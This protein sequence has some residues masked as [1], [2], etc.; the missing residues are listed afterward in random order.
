MPLAR[1]TRRHTVQKAYDAL[2]SP[3][4][5]SGSCA[6]RRKTAICSALPIG[7]LEYPAMAETGS[8]D[9]GWAQGW[10]VVR[11]VFEKLEF[12]AFFDTRE[13]AE[14]A[15]SGAGADCQVCWLFYKDAWGFHSGKR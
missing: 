2:K 13:D 11:E 10:G 7:R 8:Q 9:L 3:S 4:G 5:Y 12:V 6:S 15:A 14:T 1:D